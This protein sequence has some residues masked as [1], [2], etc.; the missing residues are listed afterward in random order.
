[1]NLDTIWQ[2]HK[3]FITGVAIGLVVF[4]IGL[5]VIGSTAGADLAARKSAIGKHKRSLQT[6]V[7]SRSQLNELTTRRNEMD[8]RIVE[9]AQ[10]ALPPLR[11]DYDLTGKPS[12]TQH[13]I[14][15]TGR[16]RT[17][18]TGWAL[19]RNV[20]IDENLGLPPQ[21]PTQPQKIAR[22]LRGLDVVERVCRLAVQT[23]AASVENIDVA[24][25]V[26]RTSR[27]NTAPVLDL[28]PVT[29]EVV[30]SDQSPRA[31]LDAVINA[32]DGLGPLGLVRWELMPED[33]R[34]KQRRVVLE[35]AAGALPQE[36]EEVL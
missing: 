35:F 30:F 17:E 25:R 2:L 4:L 21:S 33:T 18:L 19:R 5:A 3:R 16:L 13:Y 34:R 22:V 20:E 24:S 8:A 7:Y 27:R 31:F 12:A 28:T 23:G 6:Q 14:E 1:M 11:E 10:D 15:L 32:A 29:L 9:L 26:P 36:Q